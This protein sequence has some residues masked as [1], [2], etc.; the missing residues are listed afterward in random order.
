[1]RR[2]R[3]HGTPPMTPPPTQAAITSIQLHAKRRRPGLNNIFTP[4]CGGH[5]SA[6]ASRHHPRGGFEITRRLPGD[7][8]G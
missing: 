1:M 7:I 5:P 4:A 2:I 6:K 8:A 3:A